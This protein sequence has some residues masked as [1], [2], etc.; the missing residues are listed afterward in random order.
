[1]PA[2]A[3]GGEEE[4]SITGT[5]SEGE[6]GAEAAEAAEETEARR[7]DGERRGGVTLFGRLRPPVMGE[8]DFGTAQLWKKKKNLE[9]RKQ[10]TSARRGRR[11][12]C[13]TM[14]TENR[15]RRS[16]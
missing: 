15:G 9:Y 8:S 1:M 13:E 5:G 7:S 2:A 11:R 6:R 3:D 10:T 12:N 4:N 14:M 16:V